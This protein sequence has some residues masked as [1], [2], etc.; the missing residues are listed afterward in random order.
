MWRFTTINIT[1]FLRI[2]RIFSDVLYIAWSAKFVKI[3]N[4]FDFYQFPFATALIRHS[5][6]QFR[7]HKCAANIIIEN[8]TLKVISKYLNQAKPLCYLKSHCERSTC[9]LTQPFWRY[10]LLSFYSEFEICRRGFFSQP[11]LYM[12]IKLNVSDFP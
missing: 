9:T 8:Y 10:N 7:W 4:I 12:Y 6:W 3:F 1:N 5:N 2:L 11:I